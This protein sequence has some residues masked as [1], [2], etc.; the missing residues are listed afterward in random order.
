LSF[1]NHWRTIIRR[2]IDHVHCLS[3]SNLA[4]TSYMKDFFISYNKADKS[5]AEWIAWILEEAGYT[6]VIQA[7]DFRPGSNFLLDMDKA[8]R[9]SERTIIVLSPDF[10][11]ALYTQPEWA[12][13]FARDP[14]GEK[15]I[16][17]PVL[18]RECNLEGLL[19]Q[20]VHI[21]LAGLDEAAAEK[22]L[23]DGLKRDRAKPTSKPSFPGAPRSVPVKPRFPGTLPGIWNVP[24]HR[25]PNFT[26][27]EEILSQLGDLLRSGAPA[28]L[29][30][31][32]TGLGGIGKTSLALEYVYRYASDYSVVW[33]LPSEEPA[34][35]TIEYAALAKALDLPVKD[36]P[37]V[38]EIVHAVRRW[39]DQN[40]G[41]LLVFDNAVSPEELREFRPQ[42]ETGHVII[43]SRNQNWGTTAKPLTVKVWPRDE[44]T[45]FLLK[46]TY[47]DDRPAAYELADELGCLPLALEHAGAYIETRACT[48]K[49]YLERFGDRG[50]ELLE[51]IQPSAEYPFTV[52]RTWELSFEQ[53]RRESSEAADLMKLLAFFAPDDIPRDI[54][55]EGA[56]QLPEPLAIL[57]CDRVQLDDIL[58]VLRRYSLVDLQ[59]EGVSVHRLVQAVTRDLMTGE[60]KKIWTGAAAN[61]LSATYHFHP[62]DLSTWNLSQ[63]LLPHAMVS[64]DHAEK[65]QVVA[66]ETSEL[67]DSV[68]RHLR[69]LARLNEAKNALKQAL[70]ICEAAFGPD[71]PNVALI[72]SD[73]GVVLLDLGDLPGAKESLERALKIDEAVFGP[74][75]PNVAIRLSNLGLVLKNLGDLPGAKERLER[76]MR[77]DEVVLG[78]D[79][80]NVA[81]RLSNLGLVLKDLGDFPGAKERFERAM[82]IN[83]AAFGPDHPNVATVVNNLGLVLWDAGDLAGAKERVERA[84]RINEAVFGPDHPNVAIGLNNLGELLQDLG[85]LPGARE[86]L[87]RALRIGEAVFGPGHPKVAIRLNNLG[88]VLKGLGDLPGARESLERALRIDEALLGPDH[89][90]V[91]LR[92]GNLGMVL[93]GLGDLPGARESLERA[94]RIDEAVLG[95]DHPNVAIRLN[96]LGLVI[97]D[98]GDI[99]AARAHLSRALEISRK[100]LGEDHP[101]TKK[102][103]EN[104]AA[105]DKD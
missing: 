8:T 96:N 81:I 14:T 72:L 34:K 88:M 39:L 83:E 69:F 105:L 59:P 44:A 55:C 30:Q 68:G 90:R 20:I 13:A 60:E 36:S 10:V 63:R 102:V 84:M 16:L 9:E 85:D 19:A 52:V 56:P 33:W 5:W 73:L 11:T 23:L 54:L 66:A 57:V 32:I 26:G 65:L 77:I 24:H 3:S 6:T 87:E 25:N 67:L 93:K 103:R 29:T 64:A 22:A 78:P 51:R 2:S 46:R 95:P 7:W 38:P 98:L 62:N 79:H 41:W 18:V 97:R 80:S 74:D 104:L 82:R 42:G 70:S 40:S 12:A 31:A 17:I 94:L 50:P 37:N 99:D 76:A 58:A 45:D 47:Q 48:I 71:H 28:T 75:H 53:V 27:R 86:R 101:S 1:S 35:L 21:K 89:P 43:T 91:A 92:L 61:L 49:E 15:G 100:T 4:G